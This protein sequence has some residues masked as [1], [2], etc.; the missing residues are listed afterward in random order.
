MQKETQHAVDAVQEAQK[1]A[2]AP[3]VF[4]ATVTLRD[5]GIFDFIFAN[6][7]KG[8]VTITDIAEKLSLSEY[9]IGVLLE[10]AESSNIVIQDEQSKFKLTK[11]GYFLTYNETVNVNIN[12]TNDVCYK[13]LS[14][15]PEAI[16]EGR[17]AGLKELGSWSTI[18]EGLSKLPA[19]VQK[20]WFEFD[21]HYS[22]D[23]FDEALHKL[24]KYA[25]K[26][27]TDVGANTGKFALQ[28]LKQDPAIEMTLV[29]LPGQLKKALKATSEAGFENRVTG[30]EIDWLSR[31][32][33]SLPKGADIIWM[34]Q[35]L[36]CFSEEEISTI[37]N[38]ASAAMN[39][40]TRLIIIE[41]YTDRQKF[42]NAKFI[43]EA[44]S[45]YF[46]VMANGNSKM[47]PSK[48]LIE[49]IKKAGMHID[50]DITLGEYHTMLVCK[51]A[52]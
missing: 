8:G 44:T 46:T 31:K 27:V 41:T 39:D 21:H 9:G 36:D 13:G 30:Q 20:S 12:F 18:Y 10:I 35:F 23:I 33:K 50:E 4:Q 24:F 16:K 2:F 19:H 52:N 11:T 29:D 26:K 25:P 43:L 45:I 32:E 6:R 37:L 40:K 49:R 51:K 15:L 38:T 42:D 28:C 3:F 7:K 47:Y 14:H 48:V 1:I 17:P 34:C 22:D 5:L